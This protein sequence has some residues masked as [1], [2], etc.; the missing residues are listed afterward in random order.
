DVQLDRGRIGRL[1]IDAIAA[2]PDE[3]L[4]AAA[5]APLEL[6]RALRGSRTLVEAR[7]SARLVLERPEVT[8]P[9]EAQPTLL[10]FVELR[11]GMPDQ[12]DDD[13]ARA[14]VRE[15]KA[16]GGDLRALRRALTG[17]ERGPELWA[18]VACLP[19]DEAVARA[20]ADV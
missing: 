12:L 4:C 19:R 11:E 1:A 13:D 14:I 17:V 18:I 6:V 20:R 15:L 3:E 9:P 16:V 2:M 5:G 7:A 8:L 10:R